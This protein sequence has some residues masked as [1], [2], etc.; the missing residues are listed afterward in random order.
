MSF[1]HVIELYELLDNQY[2]T[3]EDVKH[4][5]S[6][7]GGDGNITVETVHGELGSTDFVKVTIPGKDG[8]SKGGNAPTL[9]II[10]RL[11][12]IGAR[13]E[14]IGFVSDGDG[15]LSAVSAA[16]KLLDMTKK[17]D[18]LIGDVI[19]TTHICPT[20][21]TLPH[22]PVPFMNS[23]VDIFT[24]NQHEVT[25]EM[26]AILSIDTTKG[27]AILNHKGFAITPTVKEGYILKISDDLLHIY[28]QSTG[29]PPVTLPITTQD[30]TPYGNGVFHI[31]SILQP[32]VATSSPVVG[33]AITTQTAV[34]GCGTG[35]THL[36]DVEQVVRFV[37]E[38][39]KGYG[40]NKC[41]FYNQE[42][43]NL[44]ESLY[45]KMDHLQTLGEQ[46]AEK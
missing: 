37:I 18:Q 41:S 33:V 7:I 38:V 2:V 40:D 13:P 17:G 36:T 21:P 19:I 25:K 23:P 11:G 26:D 4:Y 16:A 32:A 22:D 28:S 31:N 6:N 12:G 24:M 27:N 30:I 44:L 34:A 20:A 1:K 9:G 3:G 15:A 46:G 43:F 29:T 35:A 14:M 42:D 39:A 45:G 8:K 5:L 10:G